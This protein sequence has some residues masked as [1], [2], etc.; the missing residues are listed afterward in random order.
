MEVE[1]EVAYQHDHSLI[2]N[3]GS[4]FQPVRVSKE[5]TAETMR[6]EIICSSYESLDLYLGWMF[7]FNSRPEKR[8]H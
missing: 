8:L 5:L 3:D 7:S 4:G 6:D 1:N 2:I